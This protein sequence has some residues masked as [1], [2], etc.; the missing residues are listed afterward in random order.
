MKTYLLTCFLSFALVTF[1]QRD[2]E[3]IKEIDDLNS[4]AL[5]HYHN[6]KIAESFDEFSQAKVL[7]DSIEDLYGSAVANFNL[8]NI[9]GLMQN[10]ESAEACYQAM[11][12]VSKR[13][14]DNSLI[15]KSY[16][17]LGILYKDKKG[18][19]NAISYLEK[20]LKHTAINSNELRNE[21]D[22]EE[23]QKVLFR[24]RMNLAQAYLDS[25]QF[26][27]SLIPLLRAKNDFNEVD[28]DFYAL[29]YFNYVYGLYF[30]KQELYNNAE[31]KLQKAIASLENNNGDKAL[32]LL[33]NSYREL[34][35]M[36]SKA[37]NSNE[38]YANLL[39]HNTYRDKYINAERVKQDIIT[40]SKFLIEDY[41]FNAD[42]ADYKRLQQLEM[43][44]E[45]KRINII[46]SVILFLLFVSLVTLF[47]SYISKR[48][49]GNALKV[50]NKELQVATIQA[51]KSSELKS[52]F[53]S[54]VS[55]ELRTPL[56]GVVGI[57]SLL[58]N[59]KKNFSERDTKYL[60]SLKYSGDYLLNLVNDILQVNKMEAQ[61]IE[62]KNVSVNLES[63][64]QR[65]V[66]SFDYRLQETN[67]KI[68]VQ[69]DN[70][71]PDY[72]KCDNVRLSQVLINLIGN[73]IKFTE[74][75]TIDLR[76]KLLNIEGNNIALRFEVEDNGI[77]IPKEKFKTIFDNFSQLSNESNINYQGTGLG[78]SITKN[79]VQ[80]FK[81]KIE[82][83][84][85]VGK[86]TKFSFNVD[87]EI[88]KEN[89]AVLDLNKA[90]RIH[91]NSDKNYKVLIAEDNKINQIVT[92]NLLLK[93]NYSYDIVSNGLEAV[94][95]MKTN[96]FDL[97][98]MDINM[99]LMNG[100]EATKA[101]REFNNEI[102]IIAL[103]AAD[104]EE[105]RQD[106][107]VIGYTDIITK[108]FDNYEFFQTIDTHI[109]NAKSCEVNLVIAS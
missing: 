1:A 96:R 63:L 62:L 42:F 91:V 76:I 72:I 30:L 85:E 35:K 103:T 105:V 93:Q 89:K 21:F 37:G 87:F 106:Y 36:Y 80:L 57:T 4:S 83:E 47:V 46:I 33:S 69:I 56:Y 8:G 55:H 97:V 94:E 86:G 23:I 104:I 67:N 29:G 75:G 25:N 66:D 22:K 19:D 70:E 82:L 59:E 92:K 7:S 32:M 12:K 51:L 79:I 53:I 41:K 13:I 9:Y 88:D 17:S 98:L 2:R 49:L 54:N 64:T 31:L 10:Q 50:R 16:L 18:L 77:G 68:K 5:K 108:P 24:I 40:K 3:I 28:E 102:P 14:N 52:K 15:A 90:K 95:M 109:Q 65:I 100:N 99:P 43:T 81:S 48:K 58:L 60:K 45:M 20:A 101:I 39:M 73:S 84:S 11:L 26:E 78:L 107:K 34:G 6:N 71:I 27:K 74:S 38:A 44:N 61:K